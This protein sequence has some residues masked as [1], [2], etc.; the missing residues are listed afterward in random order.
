MSNALTTLIRAG[1]LGAMALTAACSHERSEATAE[2]ANA[3]AAQAAIYP[4]GIVPPAD[5]AGSRRAGIYPA[6]TPKACCFLAGTSLLVLD[7]PPGSQLVVFTFYVPSVAPLMKNRERVTVR[8]N[9]KLAAPPSELS[10]GMQDVTVTI[11]ASLRPQRHLAASLGM[12]IKWVPKTIGL[13]DD[14][15]ELSIMLI[16]VGYI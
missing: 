9:G 14:R 13:N 16:R 4:A 15:R 6:E 8:F 11:P 3:T 7:N 5:W 12:S 1:L 2:S 10:P